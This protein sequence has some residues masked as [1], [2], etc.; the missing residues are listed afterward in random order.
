MITANIYE[1]YKGLCRWTCTLELTDANKKQIEKGQLLSNGL[2]MI[3]DLRALA[4]NNPLK[5]TIL[6]I[7]KAM[8][9]NY[10]VELQ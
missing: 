2:Y 5:I 10:A 8:G 1:L 9:S 6:G 4:P 7:G 3:E